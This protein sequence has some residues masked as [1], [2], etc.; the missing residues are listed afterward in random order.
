MDSPGSI[1]RC[2]SSLP[3]R[4]TPSDTR[5]RAGTRT[6]EILLI[7]R[8]VPD[9]RE[10]DA[11]ALSVF[12][13]RLPDLRVG[14][15]VARRVAHG[16][17]GVVILKQH[18]NRPEHLAQIRFAAVCAVCGDVFPLCRRAALEEI[19]Q[20]RHQR[21]DLLVA[22]IVAELRIRFCGGRGADNVAFEL[23]FCRTAQDV[24]LRGACASSGNVTDKV[25]ERLPQAQ[26][27]RSDAARVPAERQ[28]VRRQRRTASCRR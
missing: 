20:I 5:Q 17:E 26:R 2:A 3:P 7:E 4:C 19:A 16:A 9:R 25:A 15:P 1:T 8:F 23:L 22:G 10:H 11:K 27:I 6:R 12:Q 24:G 28:R 13:K 14:D 21:E 18:Q